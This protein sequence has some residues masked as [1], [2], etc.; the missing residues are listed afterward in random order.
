MI[1]CT[2]SKRVY[3]TVY[4]NFDKNELEMVCFIKW[5][6]HLVFFYKAK[7]SCTHIR[8]LCNKEPST[9]KNTSDPRTLSWFLLAIDTGNVGD[10]VNNTAGV[11]PLVVVPGDKLDEVGI[12]GDTGGGIEDGGALVTVEIGGDDLV[13]SVAKDT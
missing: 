2:Y 5:R 9:L 6:Y 7:P 11:T 1:D 8:S 10:E 4:N 12:K 13:L 3:S